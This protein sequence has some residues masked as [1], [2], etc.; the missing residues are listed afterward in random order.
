[1]DHKGGCYVIQM[2]GRRLR[3]QTRAQ[4]LEVGKACG[5]RLFVVNGFSVVYSPVSNIGDIR[6]LEERSDEGSIVLD[7]DEVGL[8]TFLEQFV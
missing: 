7:T 3:D 6:S 1:M 4:M 5:L 8:D 2:D